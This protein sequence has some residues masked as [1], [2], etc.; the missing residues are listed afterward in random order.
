MTSFD[1]TKLNEIY[2]NLCNQ[3]TESLNDITRDF[4]KDALN[5]P[6]I[7][8]NPVAGKLN[9]L[10]QRINET[11]SKV[12]Q[13]E[14]IL[15]D[16]MTPTSPG[17]PNPNPQL[18]SIRNALS[19]IV[20]CLGNLSVST[21]TF[22]SY[23]DR[24]SGKVIDNN[25]AQYNLSAA[26]GIAS[27]YNQMVNVLKEPSKKLIDN[28]TPPFKP[29]LGQGTSLLDSTGPIATNVQRFITQNSETLGNWQN[30]A[31][32][33]QELTSQALKYRD[34]ICDTAN[35]M[36]NMI[37]ASKNFIDNAL[38]V[39]NRYGLIRQTL[40]AAISDP[41]FTGELFQNVVSTNFMKNG[42]ERVKNS[43]EE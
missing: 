7:F 33:I 43:L 26:V 27:G 5:Q 30:D 2:D 14:S 37:Q 8:Q 15:T 23:T 13:L 36:N 4:I 29:L 10:T 1:F 24:L 35:A 12:N 42:I 17:L 20:G 3:P 39:I 41:C 16:L 6:N 11:S 40:A 34:D 38:G 21:D 9:E 25:S 22:K 19:S 31:A 32:K 28:F 18:I